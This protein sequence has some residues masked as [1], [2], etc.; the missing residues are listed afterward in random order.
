MS[1]VY[2]VKHREGWCEIQHDHGKPQEGEWNTPTRCGWYVTAPWGFAR[3]RNLVTCPDCRKPG[4][5]A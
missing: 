4:E 2:A 1:G 5:S 3:G